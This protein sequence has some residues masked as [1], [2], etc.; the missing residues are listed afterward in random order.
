M[1]IWKILW[2]RNGALIDESLF[3]DFADAMEEVNKMAEE[4]RAADGDPGEYDYDL[5]DGHSYWW[6]DGTMLQVRPIWLT[7]KGRREMRS[8]RARV[9]MTCKVTAKEFNEILDSLGM[10]EE[11][12]ESADEIEFTDVLYDLFEK[13][14]KIDGDSYIPACQAKGEAK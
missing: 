6:K 4:K 14:G 9:W 5:F 7:K 3:E 12:F 8:I 10:T 2:K 13:N 1:T 11:E